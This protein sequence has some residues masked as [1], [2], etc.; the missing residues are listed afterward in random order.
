MKK[1]ICLYVQETYHKQYNCLLEGKLIG[2]WEN[3]ANHCIIQP[4]AIECLMDAMGFGP[5][6]TV[7]LAKVAT[8]HD[9][10]K[11]LQK[12]PGDFTATEVLCAQGAFKLAQ[13]N[14]GLMTATTPLFLIHFRRGFATF[15]E[16]I[17]FFV[18][19]ITKGDQIVSFD[20]RIDEVSARNPHPDDEIERQLGR[21]YWDVER[22]IGHAIQNMTLSILRDR[23]FD[24]PIHVLLNRLIDE[25]FPE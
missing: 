23:G 18:D 4:V 7:E 2:D 20:E 12:K 24:E 14:P 16:M 11:R 21:S 25:R 8:C 17:Q 15:A 22:E 10:N 6:I 13:V 3:A 19:D 5:V 9:W 1:S